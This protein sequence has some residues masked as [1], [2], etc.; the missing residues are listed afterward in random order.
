MH[1]KCEDCTILAS[2]LIPSNTFDAILHKLILKTTYF[3]FNILPHKI[4]HLNIF[5]CLNIF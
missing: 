3:S 1:Q 5:F 4:M 2:F